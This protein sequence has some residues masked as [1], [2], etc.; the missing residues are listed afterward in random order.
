MFSGIPN[1]ELAFTSRISSMSNGLI[2]YMGNYM[3]DE[4]NTLM[5]GG[6]VFFMSILVET[7]SSVKEGLG[8]TS[9]I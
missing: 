6:L 3:V 8:D 7:L 9:L 4:L 5:L 2:Y 1:G